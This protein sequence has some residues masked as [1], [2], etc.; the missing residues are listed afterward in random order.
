MIAASDL[1]RELNAIAHMIDF[2]APTHASDPERWHAEKSELRARV[3]KLLEACG[4]RLRPVALARS[5][6]ASDSGV[7]LVRSG[8]RDIPVERRR[9]R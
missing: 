2:L 4:F 9:A 7:R 6:L 8:G 5:A 1:E 3:R